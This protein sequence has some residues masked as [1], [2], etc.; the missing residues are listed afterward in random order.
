LVAGSSRSGKTYWTA[1]QVA[2]EPRLWVWDAMGEFC[3]R[4]RCEP[5]RKVAALYSA[6]LSS[7][8][9]RL[10]YVGPVTREA[11]DAW[12]R[13]AWV[14]MRVNAGAGHRVALVVEELADVTSPGKAPA[15][16][17]EIVRKGQRFN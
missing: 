4:Y 8:P 10:G 9:A 1:Q 16:W 2:G 3:A 15:A 17:G 6:A 5:V 12:C 11:F 14:W 7:S 13:F